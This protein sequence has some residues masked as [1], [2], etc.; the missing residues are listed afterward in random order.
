M[1]SLTLK[2]HTFCD[3]AKMISNCDIFFALVQYQHD[4]IFA[5]LLFC[6]ETSEKK[7]QK[8]KP[9]ILSNQFLVL[10][11]RF[12]NFQNNK[13]DVMIGRDVIFHATSGA[14]DVFFM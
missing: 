3:S 6:S 8:K 2:N 11:I 4:I 9:A 13:Y 7:N 10:K 14:N 1:V 12:S 5:L